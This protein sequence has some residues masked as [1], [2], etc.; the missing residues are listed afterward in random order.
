MYTYVITTDSAYTDLWVD[1][2]HVL[3]DGSQGKWTSDRS[4]LFSIDLDTIFKTRQN[5]RIILQTND[6]T[7][8]LNKYPDILLDSL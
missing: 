1:G 3:C 8:L 4:F 6:L 7:E 5:H 2:K